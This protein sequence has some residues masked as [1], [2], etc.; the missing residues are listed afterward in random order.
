MPLRLIR[1][2]Q[3]AVANIPLVG[4]MPS[5]VFVAFHLVFAIIMVTLI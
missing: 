3:T 5:T 4:T 1:A 2:T